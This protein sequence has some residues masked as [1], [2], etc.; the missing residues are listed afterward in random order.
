MPSTLKQNV[1]S[2]Y[3][4]TVL[5]CTISHIVRNLVHSSFIIHNLVLYTISILW[6]LTN[7]LAIVTS[8]NITHVQHTAYFLCVTMFVTIIMNHCVLAAEHIKTIIHQSFFSPITWDLFAFLLCT[9][10]CGSYLDSRPG[11]CGL[12]EQWESANIRV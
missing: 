2:L 12:T 11:L 10:D 1:F 5:I 4:Y 3:M 6:H 9:D 8:L 7:L